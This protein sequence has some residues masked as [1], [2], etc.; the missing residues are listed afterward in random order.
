MQHGRDSTL[1]Q[2]SN[3]HAQRESEPRPLYGRGQDRQGGSALWLA[4]EAPGGVVRD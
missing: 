4:V 1:R 3:V 2:P